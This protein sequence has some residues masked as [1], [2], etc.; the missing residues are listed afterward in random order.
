MKDDGID[1]NHPL[2]SLQDPY[3]SGAGEHEM[4]P[5]L[6]HDALSRYHCPPSDREEGLADPGISGD[7]VEEL[8]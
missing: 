7:S 6:E 2:R 5:A 1:E 8:G 4:E 3:A